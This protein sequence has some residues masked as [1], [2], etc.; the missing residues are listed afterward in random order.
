MAG[1]A[2]PAG[3]DMV[4]FIR[5]R[6]QYRRTGTVWRFVRRELNLQWVEEHPVGMIG[7]PAD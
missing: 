2:E 4:W 5:Y 3:T 6:D 1:T 7:P